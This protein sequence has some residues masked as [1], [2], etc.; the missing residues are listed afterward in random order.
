[1]TANAPL[2]AQPSPAQADPAPLGLAGFGASALMI[3]LVNTGLVER[4]T[5]EAVLPVGLCLGGLGMLIASNWEIRRGN[6]FA[7]TAFGVYS[8]FWL[9]LVLYFWK[10]AA[11][12][13]QPEAHVA[14]G[15]FLLVFTI[16]TGY[17]MVASWRGRASVAVVITLLFTSFV[18]LCIG[19][20]AQV[21]SA[22]RIGGWLGVAAAVAGFYASGE[23]VIKATWRASAAE[24]AVGDNALPA[25]AEASNAS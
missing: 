8:G 25:A 5:I 23:G 3:G 14:L 19:A 22:T 10:F 16:I 6:T 9:A 4:S 7:G 24:G 18:P 21:E 2:S 15:L 11:K 1:M 17:L 13:P 20:F 12:V